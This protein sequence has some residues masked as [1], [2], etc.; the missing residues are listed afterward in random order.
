[1][2][3]E[4]IYLAIF[5]GVLLVVLT[6]FLIYVLLRVI[7]VKA[8]RWQAALGTLYVLI[9]VWSFVAAHVHVLEASEVAHI[10]G[11]CYTPF[12]AVGRVSFYVWLVLVHGAQLGIWRFGVKLPPLTLVLMQVFLVAGVVLAGTTL[13]QLS[14]HSEVVHP[15]E[16]PD[17]F[18]P[19]VYLFCLL[20]IG[21]SV[22]LLYKAVITQVQYAAHKVYENKLLDQFNLFLVTYG[23]QREWMLVFLFPVLLVVT[24]I[25]TLLG[26]E[27]DAMVRLF[28][29]TATWRLSQKMHP[30]VLEAGGSHYL[31]TVAT[32]GHP[33]IVKP[34][35]IGARHG[36]PIIVNRQLQ[37][38]NAFEA[39]LQEQWPWVH[40]FVRRVYDRYGWNI[41]LYINSPL[42][43][44]MTYVMMKPLEWCFLLY[45]Y[46]FCLAPEK[47]IR[48]QYVK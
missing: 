32:A 10:D 35:R 16:W 40:A 6:P 7:H 2:E 42:K 22:R 43:A 30:P 31:C 21:I 27:P 37:I 46:L 5:V 33:V 28:T 11:S 12:A 20:H 38:A 36:R 44:T 15:G 13:V 1:M 18:I 17:V 48:S 34:L 3:N 9:G 39:L 24:A 41:S 23:Q 14:S 4:K 45:L 19:V 25:L 26:Q 29:D 8:P 47:K